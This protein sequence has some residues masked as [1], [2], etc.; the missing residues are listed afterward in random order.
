MRQ[1]AD[2]EQIRRQNRGLVLETLR[3]E[4]RL[5]RVELGR[6]TGLSPATITSISADLIEEQIIRLSDED[7]QD[8]VKSG[9]G[10]PLI[11]LEINADAALVLAVKISIDEVDFAVAD[12]KGTILNRSVI[13][14]PTFDADPSRFGDQLLEEATAYLRQNDIPRQRIRHIG[15]AVQGIADMNQGTIVWSP[16]FRARNISIAAPLAQAFGTSCS[17]ANDANMIAQS[18]LGR[19][20]ARFGGTAAVVYV[21]PGIGMGLIIG[22]SIY[23][24]DSGSAAEFGHMNHVPEGPI[25]RC[26]RRG[27]VEAYAANYGIYRAATGSIEADA[28]HSAVAD[29]VMAGLER[30]ARAGHQP[31]LKAFQDAGRALGFGIAR[32]TAL[33]SPEKIFFAG[34][35][36]RAFSLMEKDLQEGLE[37]GLV[38]DLRR[39]LVLEVIEW[40]QDRIIG[41]I[42]AG[43]LRHLDRDVFSRPGAARFLDAA[44]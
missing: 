25:C 10:R 11:R 5:A 32:V 14:L 35:G 21:G 18:M 42:V 4:G 8:H 34:P 33:L 15:V 7:M 24:G 26:G 23:S 13:N 6:A 38:A 12:Y 3:R 16:A 9:P 22:G 28:P 43:A 20:L 27:C 44:Q 30:D 19:E 37:S 31:A 39:E 2:S 29:H 1:K 36:T 40:N 17:I 41:G